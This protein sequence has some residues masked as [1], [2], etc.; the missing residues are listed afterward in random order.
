MDV[1]RLVSVLEDYSK[2]LEEDGF[3]VKGGIYNLSAPVELRRLLANSGLQY[4]FLFNPKRIKLSDYIKLRDALI[5]F[6][7]EFCLDVQK[8][9]DEISEYIDD[10]NI[11][12]KQQTKA[13]LT[14]IRKEYIGKA[15]DIQKLHNCENKRLYNDSL[16][17][18]FYFYDGF[19]EYKYDVTIHMNGTRIIAIEPM[20]GQKLV[21]EGERR[22]NYVSCRT[23]AEHYAELRE[24][25][26][27]ATC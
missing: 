24:I 8:Q 3:D 10:T 7:S 16:T 1:L 12:K 17:F 15:I 21:Y 5:E 14:N 20:Q 2:K 25:L 26:E 13:S 23:K 22:V 18:Y 4:N 11:K 9:I 27:K 19:V 6:Q